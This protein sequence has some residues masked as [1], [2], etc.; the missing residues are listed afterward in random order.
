MPDNSEKT[1]L[2]RLDDLRANAI[3]NIVEN[4]AIPFVEAPIT[5]PLR[6][7]MAKTAIIEVKAPGIRPT[8]KGG[9][10]RL[11]LQ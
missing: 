1:N 2:N 9:I 10:G 8:K 7:R 5:S 3:P 6:A 11:E 4:S